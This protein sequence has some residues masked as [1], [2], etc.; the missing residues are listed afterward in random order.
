MQ[1]HDKYFDRNKKVVDMQIDLTWPA[2]YNS[3]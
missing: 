1:V 2:F 3:N